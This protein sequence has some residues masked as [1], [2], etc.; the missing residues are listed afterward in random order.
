MAISSNTKTVFL[1]L[2]LLMDVGKK[3][4]LK[5][6]P[7]SLKKLLKR[8]RLLAAWYMFTTLAL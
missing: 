7:K 6:V 1:G 2:Q 3:G 8:N 5:M 4:R